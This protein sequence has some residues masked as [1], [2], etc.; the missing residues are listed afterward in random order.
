MI[1]EKELLTEEDILKFDEEIELIPLTFDF[2]Y[3]GCFVRDLHFLKKFLLSTLDTEIDI[4]ENSIR[5]AKSMLEKD[6]DINL[7]SEISNL[8][9]EEIIEIKNSL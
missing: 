4:D 6:M 5:V 9:I 1:K 3:K 2:V 7:I 8:S